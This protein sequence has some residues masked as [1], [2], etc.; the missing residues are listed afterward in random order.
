M[1]RGKAKQSK[2]IKV[3]TYTHKGKKRKNNPHVGLVSSATDKL[4]GRTKYKHDPHIDPALSW[5]GKAEGMSIEVQ[6]VSLHIHERID[7]K[8]IVKA[9]LKKKEQ[10]Q[11][12]L[13]LF[14]QPD[15]EPPLNK[16]IDFYKHEQDWTNRL[17]AGDSLLVMNSLLNK[18]G[19]AGK[20]QMIYI[21][22]PYGINYNSNFQPFVNQTQ[23]KDRDEDIPAEPEM[24]QA[25]RDTW[26]LG[27]HSYL[28]HL[29][30]RLLLAKELL[31]ESGSVFVQISDDNVHLV[32]QVM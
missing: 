8:R 20:V 1:A 11:F 22:P 26:E 9:F 3:E 25:F 7:P 24:I 29:R 30:D 32:R 2:D 10:K 6:N 16:A 23:V 28:T 5:A 27:I 14:E 31:H 18:E 15:N 21:D 12:Q 13:D 19:M 4:N 17:I